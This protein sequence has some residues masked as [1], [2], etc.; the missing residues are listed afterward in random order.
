MASPAMRALSAGT[1]LSSTSVVFPEPETPVTTVSRPFGISRPSARTV[2]SGFVRSATRP[3]A[4]ISSRAARL[5]AAA[6]SRS[7]RKPPISEAGL[8]SISFIV[9]S[10]TTLPPP[11]PAPGPISI[12]HSAA[13]STRVSWST[14]T[15]ELPCETRSRTTPSSPSTFAGCSPIDGSSRT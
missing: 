15:T 4:N 2:C 14:I 9:P 11:A 1:R 3:F 7:A 6:G 5:R 8:F 12:I 10:A 13:R